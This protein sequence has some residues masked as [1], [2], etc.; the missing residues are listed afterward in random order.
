MRTVRET[1]EGR[2]GPSV[3]DHINTFLEDPEHQRLFMQERTILELTELICRQ[4]KKQGLS[5]TELASRIGKSKGQVTQMLSG[6]RNL[7]LRS[8]SDMLLALGCALEPM[9]RRVEEPPGR[10][11]RIPDG[12]GHQWT[13]HGRIGTVGMRDTAPIRIKGIA[14]SPDRR[15]TRGVA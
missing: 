8:L 2:K 9:V 13:H 10:Y 1:R 12:D 3:A 14:A 4:M 5:R 15:G 11:V 7:T 6:G